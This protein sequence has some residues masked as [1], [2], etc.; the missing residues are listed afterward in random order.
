MLIILFFFWNS[1]PK[2]IPKSNPKD[3]TI[4]DSTCP[5]LLLKF[6]KNGI[7]IE[8]AA[9]RT[10]DRKARGVEGENKQ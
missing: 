2:I 8:N 7:K 1:I 4:V 3:N 5:I 6:P 9:T 10:K